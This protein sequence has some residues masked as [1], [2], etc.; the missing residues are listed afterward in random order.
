MATKSILSD[1]L[2]EIK[3]QNNPVLIFDFDGVIA[4]TEPLHEIAY[5]Q[6]LSKKL[7][8]KISLDWSRYKGNSEKI[9][10][11]MLANDFGL[12]LSLFEDRQ[13]RLNNVFEL[14][15]EL[16]ISPRSEVTALLQSTLCETYILSSQEGSFIQRCLVYW[17]LES[18]F[19][20]ITSLA[21][22]VETKQQWISKFI[23]SSTSM[24]NQ[25]YYFEDTPKYLVEAAKLGVATVYFG[26]ED[27]ISETEVTKWI[28]H[29]NKNTL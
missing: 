25:I 13:K 23:G 7:C 12:T 24:P 20:G 16:R 18:K 1:L 8:S 14:I 21:D 26:D 28:I 11:E 17:G 10:Y 3:N 29:P 22:K 15:K 9:I 5:N 27:A 6:L 4:D 2:T 19:N